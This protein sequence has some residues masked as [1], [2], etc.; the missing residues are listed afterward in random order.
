MTENKIY[1]GWVYDHQHY[2]TAYEDLREEV[3]L[4]LRGDQKI[5]AMLLG[6]SGTGKTEMLR[7]IEQQFA[8]R[9]THSGHPCVLYVSFPAGST[10]DSVATRIIKAIRKVPVVKGTAFERRESAKGLL[11]KA[12]ILLL[13]LDET[14][15]PVELRSA[16]STQTKA[17]RLTA[18]WIKE[19]FEGDKDW[20]GVSVILSGLPHSRRLLQ[21]NDQ[22]ESRAMRPIEV[23]SYAWHIEADRRAFKELVKAF[24]GNATESGWTISIP[25]DHLAR[26]VYLAG[27]G[28]VRPVKRLFERAVLVTGKGGA[29]TEQ[30]FVRAYDKCIPERLV[31][32]P[33]ELKQIT[34]DM[35]NAAHRQLLASLHEPSQRDR[36]A[37]SHD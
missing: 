6:H 21:D 27:R 11:H 22:L 37:K 20:D 7:D 9:V 19:L 24:S 29:L 25:D 35:L 5:V 34:D 2:L 12:G 18:D 23:K 4:V 30:V 17:N 8:D 32:N 13:I 15:H 36:K 26:A 3:E 16:R 10:S 28:L 14:N 33:F 1:E 31:G